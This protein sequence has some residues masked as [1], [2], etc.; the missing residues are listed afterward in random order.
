MRYPEGTL[1]LLSG[2][3]GELK[4][5]STTPILG[6]VSNLLLGTDEG[7]KSALRNA[8]RAVMVCPGKAISWQVLACVRKSI[9]G[10]KS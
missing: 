2:H 6:A 10:Q 4:S 9:E 5:G 7:L 3:E 8:Q 1:A